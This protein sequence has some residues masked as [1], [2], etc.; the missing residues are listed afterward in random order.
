MNNKQRYNPNIHHRRSIRLEG[1]DYYEHIIRD[2]KSYHRISEYI[3]NN[4]AKW[5]EDKFYSK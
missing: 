4:P 2:E 3:I 5:A 1:H